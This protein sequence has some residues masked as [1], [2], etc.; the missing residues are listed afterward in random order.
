MTYVVPQVV[1]VFD[2]IGQNLPA[3]T[4]GLIAV[5]DFMRNNGVLMLGAIALLVALAVWL[6]RFEDNRR[7]VHRFLLRV[8]LVGRLVR[9]LETGRFA[10]TFSILTASGV[11]VLEA[12]RISAQVISSIP[13]REAVNEAAARVR[14]GAGIAAA[15]E[16]SG[17]FPPMTVHLIA[18]GEASGKLEEMLERAA[19]NQEREIETLIAA[20]LGLFEPML[21]LLMGG[22]VLVIVLAI[23]LPIF[24]LNQLV[25]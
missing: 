9:G 12:L 13:M 22:V 1:Q 5:S 8:P 20:V 24:D 7:V 10:R 21:I 14:E 2:N 17:Y 18:S 3:L 23:L 6:M 11:P 16:R 19:I 4:V 25:Q 15:L